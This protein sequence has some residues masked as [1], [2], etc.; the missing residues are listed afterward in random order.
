MNL[1]QSTNSSITQ[2]GMVSTIGVGL[3]GRLASGET[4]NAGKSPTLRGQNRKSYVGSR[5][6]QEP[7]FGL[8]KVSNGSPAIRSSDI[9]RAAAFSYRKFAASQIPLE[10]DFARVLSS[11][12]WDLYSR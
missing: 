8:I 9:A 1:N 4:S 12:L 10:P 6:W 11:N 2:A 3:V 5:R 7:T